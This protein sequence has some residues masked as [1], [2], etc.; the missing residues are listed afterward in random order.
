MDSP[1]ALSSS[2]PGLTT[3]SLPPPPEP[4][5][6]SQDRDGDEELLPVPVSALNQYLYCKRRCALI[7]LEGIFPTNAFVEHGNAI[8]QR[9]DQPGYRERRGCRTVRALPIFSDRL[10]LTGRADIVEFWP[11]PSGTEEPRP[12][13]YKRG[14]ASRWVNDHVQLCAQALCLEEM[15]RVQVTKGSIYHAL[16]RRRTTV[17]FDAVLRELT[18]RVIE[19]VRALLLAGT[20]PPPVHTVRCH[21][22]SFH[23][24]CLPEQTAQSDHFTAYLRQVTHPP[25]EE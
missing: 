2:G 25:V 10:G 15:F 17:H 11:T 13:D 20:I 21:G 16:S 5:T 18:V 14:K 4:L 12:V 6:G 3:P 24:V 8:H 7:H 1:R 23:P 22:C 19:E 9:V